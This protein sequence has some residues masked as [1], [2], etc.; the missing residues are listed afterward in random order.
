[1]A[2]YFAEISVERRRTA[3]DAE[4][5]IFILGGQSRI[6]SSWSSCLGI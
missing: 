4:I 3:A 2:Y 1:M 6:E 5:E